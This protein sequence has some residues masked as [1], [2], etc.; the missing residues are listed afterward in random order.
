MECKW[1]P[2]LMLYEDYESWDE[3]QDAIYG[4]FCDDFKKSYP[5]YDGKRVKIRYQP[6]EYNREEGFYHVTC[7]DYQKDGERVPDLRRCERI[8]WVRKFIEH[9]DCNL[10]ECTECEGMK[11]WE[12]DY[13]NNKRV[14]ILLE[15]EKYM[16]VI[17]KRKTYCLLITAFY[18]EREH[19]LQKKL[20]KYYQYKKDTAKGASLCETPSGT[21]STSGR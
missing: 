11:V 16:V 6:I 13:H 9:Y 12:Q 10:D 7:Q 1:L 17:E 2:E 14:H 3:Y 8:K 5:I 21:P 20:K 15:E 18:I 4:V 19:T